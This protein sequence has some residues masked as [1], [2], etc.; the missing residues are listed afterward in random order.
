MIKQ[1]NIF[2]A[3]GLSSHVLQTAN[4]PL[5][6]R[7]VVFRQMADEARRKTACAISSE[8]RLDYERLARSWEELISEIT[9]ATIASKR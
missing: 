7:I 9:A 5:A 8:A 1:R 3:D 6:A 4:H 2:V